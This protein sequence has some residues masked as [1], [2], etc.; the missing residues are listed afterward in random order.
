MNIGDYCNSGKNDASF[1][2]RTRIKDL[3]KGEIFPIDKNYLTEIHNLIRNIVERINEQ[4]L[5][6]IF[7]EQ[8]VS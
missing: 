2:R 8:I 1:S 3:Q 7:L 5:E 6:T 4:I